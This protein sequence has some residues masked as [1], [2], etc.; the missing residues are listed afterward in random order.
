MWRDKCEQDVR[1]SSLSSNDV[2]RTVAAVQKT[3]GDLPLFPLFVFLVSLSFLP[4]TFFLEL[5]SVR[6]LVLYTD[7]THAGRVSYTIIRTRRHHQNFIQDRRPRICPRSPCHAE[8][9]HPQLFAWTHP[10]STH[11]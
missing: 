4:C 10:S 5:L 7:Q 6:S 9:A 8:K 2:D 1:A 11:Q 3:S